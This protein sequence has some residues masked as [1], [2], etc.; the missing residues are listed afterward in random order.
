MN[1][2]ENFKKELKELLQKYDATISFEYDPDSDTY[3][4]YDGHI[5]LKIKEN[6]LRHKHQNY[7][8]LIADDLDE[9]SITKEV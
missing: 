2:V 1:E 6:K 5:E 4:I 7:W 3:G 8:E 9:Y